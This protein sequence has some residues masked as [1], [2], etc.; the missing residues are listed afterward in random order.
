MFS[1]L[2]SVLCSAQHPVEFFLSCCSILPN[3]DLSCLQRIWRMQYVNIH[4]LRSFSGKT[5]RSYM[6]VFGD[7]SWSGF[8][9]GPKGLLTLT[10]FSMGGGRPVQLELGSEPRRLICSPDADGWRKPL[11]FPHT[12]LQLMPSSLI[13]T[14]IENYCDST[15]GQL[16]SDCFCVWDLLLCVPCSIMQQC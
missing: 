16:K 14:P 10:L 9:L 4:W 15:G 6:D 3:C 13:P 11:P 7:C 2:R 12:N 5:W 8:V 1:P